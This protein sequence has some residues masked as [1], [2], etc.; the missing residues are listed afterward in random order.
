MDLDLSLGAD[1]ETVFELLGTAP[2]I[3]DLGNLRHDTSG[4]ADLRVVVKPGDFERFEIMIP[5][6]ELPEG[7]VSAVLG[8]RGNVLDPDLDLLGITKAR[9]EGLGERARLEFDVRRRQGELT[10]AVDEYV[11]IVSDP[12][13]VENGSE[14][15]KVRDDCCFQVM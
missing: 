8:L 13:Y 11:K 2:V 15:V 1:G 7:E 6:L 10:A 14:L 3:A 12:K 9:V 5:D 4:D